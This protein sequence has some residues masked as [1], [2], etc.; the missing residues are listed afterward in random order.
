MRFVILC[1]GKTERDVLGDLLRKWLNPRVKER[2]GFTCPNLEGW[3]NVVAEAQKKA[4]LYFAE[5][6][7]LG[8]ISLID[9]YGPDKARFYPQHIKTASERYKWGIEHM[10]KEV[11]HERYRH[12]FAV[13]EVE[14]WLLSQPEHLPPAVSNKLPGKA[15]KPE[16]VNFDE[17]PAK[18]LKRLYREAL[19]KEY[20]KISDGHKLFSK[21]DPEIVY[22]KCPAFKALADDLLA[23]C[24]PAMRA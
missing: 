4:R 3:Q 11:G 9:L 6:D 10:Q 7:V 21:L 16:S 19:Q 14:A 8:V 5:K 23:L 18:L 1:E 2:I 12:H 13:H 22:R 20:L 15:A 24:P 17:P